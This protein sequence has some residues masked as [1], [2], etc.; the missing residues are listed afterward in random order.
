MLLFRYLSISLDGDIYRLIVL[1]YIAILIL[2]DR[3]LL[4]LTLDIVP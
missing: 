3:H 2:I 4:L 1:V